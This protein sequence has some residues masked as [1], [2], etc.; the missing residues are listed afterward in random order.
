MKKKDQ[1]ATQAG[2]EKMV[3]CLSKGN[4]CE[5]KTLTH[6]G[7]EHGSPNSFFNKDNRYATTFFL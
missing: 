4:Y 2:K 5:V 3:L 6:P 7:F 1:F